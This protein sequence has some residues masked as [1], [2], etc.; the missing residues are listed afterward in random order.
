MPAQRF[1]ALVLRTISAKIAKNGSPFNQLSLTDASG[2]CGSTVFSDKPLYE[3]S[4]TLQQGT[5]VFFSGTASNYMG[6]P[7]P[8]PL[9]VEA[10]L[11][12]DSR[13]EEAEE[14]TMEASQFSKE[15]MTEKLAGYVAKIT[16]SDIRFAIKQVF[17]EGS[18]MWTTPCSLAGNRPYRRGLMEYLLVCCAS[19]EGMAKAYP[20]DTDIVYATLLLYATGKAYQS[21]E[22]DEGAAESAAFGASLRSY[23]W[24][25]QMCGDP[26]LPHNKAVAHGILSCG[27]KMQV[28]PVTPDAILVNAILERFHGSHGGCEHLHKEQRPGVAVTPKID[29]LGTALVLSFGED[30][31]PP[32]AE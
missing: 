3:G 6:S 9:C 26:S 11:P 18:P 19:V 23:N 32:P 10:I 14:A 25:N 27:V 12:G 31:P 21:R 4:K 16:R 29:A 17:L 22:G 13:Y 8:R 7:A 28:K 5:L 24:F 1:Y 20:V 30:A 15:I 2:T